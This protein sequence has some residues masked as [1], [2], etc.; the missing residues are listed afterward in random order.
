[1]R[2]APLSLGVFALAASAAS[3]LAGDIWI[4]NSSGQIDRNAPLGT[5]TVFQTLCTQ[6]NAMTSIGSS[7]FLA[8]SFG[9]LWKLDTQALSFEFLS[10]PFVTTSLAAHNGDLLAGSAD[11]KLRRIR[12]SDGAILSTMTIGATVDALS[13][14]GDTVFIGG[15][16][17]LIRKG[18]VS[19]P[20][21]IIGAC[22]GQVHSLAVNGGELLAA[23][24]DGKV[25]RINKA[26][27]QYLGN[28][29]LPAGMGSPQVAMDGAFLVTGGNDGLLRWLNPTTGVVQ[30]STATCTNIRALA[31]VPRCSV[32]T[33]RDGQL[34]ANDFSTYINVYAATSPHADINHDSRF[35]VNDFVAFINAYAV[36][37][38]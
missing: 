16:D 2:T 21:N 27:G 9:N 3:A 26:T 8:D 5:Q 11:G 25:Y 37:C 1:M 19:G 6:V 15:H 36:G 18:S 14:E 38:P 7:L 29:F 30:F 28:Y 12:I 35:N 17:T 22:G 20:F 34:T 23:A 24:L 10:E 31:V 32:D 4:G 13:V 33:D